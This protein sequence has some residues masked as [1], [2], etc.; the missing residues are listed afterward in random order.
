MVDD[1][2]DESASPR[3]RQITIAL[4]AFAAALAIA[5]VGAVLVVQAMGGDTQDHVHAE[6]SDDH[7]HDE[8]VSDDHPHDEDASVDH[9]HDEDV[10][11]DHPHENSP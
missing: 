9:A 3:K 1:R 7:A 11:D 2:H 5:I 8:D 6:T 4:V 10:S